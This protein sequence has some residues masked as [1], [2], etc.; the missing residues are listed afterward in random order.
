[1]NRIMSST[2]GSDNSDATKGSEGTTKTDP[3]TNESRITAEDKPYLDRLIDEQKKA[4][5]KQIE[6]AKQI[7]QSDY[8]KRLKTLEDENKNLK[9][10]RKEELLLFL[11]EADR[12]KY[13]DK[14]VEQIEMLVEW[15]KDHP[16][17]KRGMRRK[18]ATNSDDSDNTQK[19]GTGEVGTYDFKTGKWKTS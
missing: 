17:T 4:E 5:A 6:K 18:P 10:K 7:E 15:I 9:E 8:E 13:S 1:M 12:K 19:T 11:D 2:E 16:S 3:K 14:S